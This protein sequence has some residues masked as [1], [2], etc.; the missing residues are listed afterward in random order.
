M[1]GHRKLTSLVL[2]RAESTGGLRGTT[3]WE[4]FGV[5]GFGLEVILDRC[6]SE[7]GDRV[8]LASC[9]SSHRMP[10]QLL[11]IRVF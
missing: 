10:A 3:R 7:A 11:C 4:D 2:V 5:N 9:P 6:W 1:T 8:H